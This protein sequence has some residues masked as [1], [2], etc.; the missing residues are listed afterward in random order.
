MEKYRIN[1]AERIYLLPNAARI[2]LLGTLLLIFMFDVRVANCTDSEA[3]WNVRKREAI[4][5]CIKHMER[6]ARIVFNE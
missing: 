6:G 4:L 1:E 3:K 5:Y 2:Y